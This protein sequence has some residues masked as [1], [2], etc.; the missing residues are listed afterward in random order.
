ME[1]LQERGG[2]SHSSPGG[3][4]L[5]P[6]LGSASRALPLEDP[7]TL[8]MMLQPL[9]HQPE[10]PLLSLHGKHFLSGLSQSHTQSPGPFP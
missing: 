6:H 3:L 4:L 9:S 5:A 2:W 10:G 1:S 8:W 7:T